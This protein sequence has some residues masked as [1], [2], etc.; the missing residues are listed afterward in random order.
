MTCV[1]HWVLESPGKDH[2][3]RGRCK[4][5]GQA[6]TIPWVS[7]PDRPPLTGTHDLWNQNELVKLISQGEED[8]D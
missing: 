8:D 6:T 3:Q 7:L 1:H 5:C 2:M 4:V